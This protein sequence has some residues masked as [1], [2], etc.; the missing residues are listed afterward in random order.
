MCFDYTGGNCLWASSQTAGSV[1]TPGFRQANSRQESRKSAK[2]RD[3]DT[4]IRDRLTPPTA[5]CSLARTSFY[6]H[7][8][9]RSIK[10]S[11]LPNTNCC[12]FTNPF[13]PTSL[14]L[15]F[16]SF[17]ISQR[18]KTAL[19]GWKL[20]FHAQWLTA[21]RPISW[22]YYNNGPGG[23]LRPGPHPGVISVDGW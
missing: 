23:Q 1:V 5:V 4:E 11:A 21:G 2:R 12:S 3:N 6:T 16:F 10:N 13:K 14:A 15:C 9:M 20:P 22:T 7:T 19:W 8:C 18:V 17:S